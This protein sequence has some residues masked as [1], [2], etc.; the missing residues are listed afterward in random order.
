MSKNPVVH[1]EMPAKDKKRV[2]QFYSQAFGWNMQQFGEEMDNY[3]VAQ[4]TET[5]DKGIVQ[6]PG[7]INGGFFEYKNE[8]GLNTPHLV[9]SVE[10]L[11]QSIENIKS[12]GGQIFGEIMDIP[13][14]GKYT[15]F[16]DSEGNLVGMLQSRMP[17][18]NN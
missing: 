12:A 13:N 2:A 4:T 17:S 9:I 16:R 1:F 3:L 5:D 10:N 6:T 8:E 11:D 7:T 14:I 15:S 18:S